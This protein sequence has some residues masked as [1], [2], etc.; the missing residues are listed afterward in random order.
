MAESTP[1]WCSQHLKT[2]GMPLLCGVDKLSYTISNFIAVDNTAPHLAVELR[3]TVEHF[4]S[5][6]A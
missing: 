6:A 2:A 3:P 1:A 4:D 5:A